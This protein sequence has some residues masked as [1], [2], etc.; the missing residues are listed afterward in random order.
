[1]QCIACILQTTKP[2]PGIRQLKAVDTCF[3]GGYRVMRNSSLCLFLL[4]LAGCSTGIVVHDEMRAAELI[5]DFLSS[6]K[7]DEGKQLAYAWTD[8]KFKEEISPAEF[9]AMVESIRNKNKGADIRLV[10]YEILGAV[11]TIIVYAV[12]EV[13]DE[14]NYFRFILVGTRSSDYYLLK[15]DVNA[16][17]YSKKGVYNEYQR[18]ILIQGV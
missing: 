9:F 8:D 4:L 12:S 2:S 3:K 16:S 18:A 10:G 11:E 17:E 14:K 6:F 7:S 15:L 1:M 13:G 5:V